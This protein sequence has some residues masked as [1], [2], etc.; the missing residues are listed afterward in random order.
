MNQPESFGPLP[1]PE[2]TLCPEMLGER[3]EGRVRLQGLTAFTAESLEGSLV[4]GGLEPEPEGIEH[5]PLY[6]PDLGI[7]DELSAAQFRETLLHVRTFE[8]L[9]RAALRKA[10]DSCRVD[11]KRLEE[12]A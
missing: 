6:G 8:Q 10:F 5:G 3:L 7:V 11:V 1:G 4:A 2:A 9:L 12:Q